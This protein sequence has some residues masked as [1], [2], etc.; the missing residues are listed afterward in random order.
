M[1]KQPSHPKLCTLSTTQATLKQC[2]V[3]M[4]SWMCHDGDESSHMHLY[5]NATNTRHTD[6]ISVFSQ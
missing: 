2:G 1:S 3:I 5:H 6:E 4:N